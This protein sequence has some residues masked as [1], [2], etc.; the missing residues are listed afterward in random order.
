MNILIICHQ[1]PSPTN[2]L[3]YR[4]FYCIEYLSKKY[5]HDITLIAFGNANDTDNEVKNLSFFCIKVKI[6]KISLL[7]HK[8]LFDY[9]I[10]CLR[11]ISTRDF[12]ILLDY[13]YSKKMQELID[14]QLMDVDFDVIFADSPYMLNYVVKYD[15]PKVMEIWSIPQIN[16]EAY[17]KIKSINFR[18]LLHLALYCSARSYEKN[19]KF[20]DIC[21]AP[22]EQERDLIKSYLPG[23]E[24]SAIPFGIDLPKI[25]KDIKEDYPSVAFMGN[26]G[27]IFNQKAVIYFYNDI[28][29]KI[30]RAFPTIKLYVIGSNPS[31]EVT[32]LS[33]DRSVIITGYVEDIKSCLFPISVIILPIHG[34]GI[35]TRL[36]E[37]MAAGKAVVIS[38]E[39]V[40]GINVTPGNDVII[41][42]DP[43]D[44]AEC[45]IELLVNNDFRNLIGSNAR[46]LMEKEYSWEI[47][48]GILNNVLLKAIMMHYENN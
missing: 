48:S 35:K 44:F 40:H 9:A 20:F 18:K 42:D 7:T 4:V 8:R 23:L 30:K 24:I 14:Q 15:L 21:I 41:S 36:L 38:S 47:I 29:P 10:N 43:E 26:M 31:D 33:R 27:S 2:P 12:R 6:L 5:G 17:K 16:L 28:Y 32:Q 19:Y 22:T 11:C 25:P 3:T 46:L 37:A 13:T 39:G 1:I 45:V 34:Y